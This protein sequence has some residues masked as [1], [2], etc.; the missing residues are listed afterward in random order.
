MRAIVRCGRMGPRAT[1]EPH[2]MHTKQRG[3]AGARIVSAKRSMSPDRFA[4]PPGYRVR[5]LAAF[6]Q[7]GLTL[8]FTG[9]ALGVLVQLRRRV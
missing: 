9:A 5:P 2:S 7:T 4:C 3:Q 8:G 1:G 6:R